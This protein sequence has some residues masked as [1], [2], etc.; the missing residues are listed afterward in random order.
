VAQLRHQVRRAAA[1]RSP[2]PAEPAPLGELGV[3]RGDQVVVAAA[4]VG[5]RGGG[6]RIEAEPAVLDGKRATPADLDS[7]LEALAS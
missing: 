5:H 2:S 7:D 6:R 3:D 4:V 1:G